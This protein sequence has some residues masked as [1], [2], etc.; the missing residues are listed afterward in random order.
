MHY[1]PTPKLDFAFEFF[2]KQPTLN[3][4]RKYGNLIKLPLGEHK[5][6]KQR[7]QFFIL[8][9]KIV[10]LS[11]INQNIKHIDEIKR[12]N[13][14]H[15]ESIIE[16]Y[17]HIVK[18]N[19]KTLIKESYT[20]NRRRFYEQDY[21]K[22][23]SQCGA[24]NRLKDKA[25]LGKP[26]S[27]SEI[28]HLSNTLLSVK[29]SAVEIHKL[30]KSSFKNEYSLEATNRE[31]ALIA[32]FN[33]ANCKTLIK[34]GICSGYCKEEFINRNEDP[35]LNNTSPLH[36]LTSIKIIKENN[37]SSNLLNKIAQ[38]ENISSAY[39]K[40]R[41]YHKNEDVL[42]F[43]EFDFEFFESDFDNNIQQISVIFKNKI[44]IPPIN[45]EKVV[46]TKKIDEKGEKAYR[47][48][49]IFPRESG[50]NEERMVG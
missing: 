36:F 7:S 17:S 33:P 49:L 4:K 43:D 39:Y 27:H 16:K 13:S 41:E 23:Y 5:K 12:V 42:F 14:T 47:E 11:D 9:D 26:L 44:K 22:L 30:I 2:P 37:I 32:Q 25:L 29:D 48:L 21:T 18:Y 20:S 3:D 31:L 38:P 6:Y 46:I 40:L 19:S 35:L 34:K 45:Y 24:I 28:F 50:H 10:L 15:I 8:N 1:D